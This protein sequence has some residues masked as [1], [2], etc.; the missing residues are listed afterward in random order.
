M[1]D[2][3]PI[4]ILPEGK[5]REQGKGAQRTNIAAARQVADTIRTTLGPLGQDKMLVSGMGDI[6]ITNDGATI[7][8][9]M[10]LE[11]P[12]AKMIAE[13]AKMQEK[14]TGDGTTTAVVIAGELLKNAESLMELNI[15]P[16][17]I[18]KG[19]TMAAEKAVEILEKS[20]ETISMNDKQSLT[21]IAMTAL[22]G[23][24]AEMGQEAFAKLAVNAV[25]TVADNGVDKN[26]IKIVK[27]A[28]SSI[29]ASELIQGLILD[30]ERMHPDMPRVVKQAKIL[31]TDAAIEIRN[32]E[33]KGKLKIRQPGQ[34]QQFLDQ[35]AA[36]I[37][38]IV[39][40]IADSGATALFSQKGVDD[41]AQ[42]MLAKKGIYA[43]RRVMRSD[44]EALAKA[45][46]GRIITNF[47]EIEKDDIGY[48]GSVEGIKIGDEDMTLVKDCKQ[49][50]AVSILLR[51]A[52]E[53]VLSEL[54]RALDDAISVLATVL[55]EGKIV[56][57]AGAPEI[58]T[59][60]QLRKFAAS[61]KGREQL[62]V[63]AFADALEVIPT[64]LAENAGLD[65]ITV[66][67]EVKA[68]H[69]KGKKWEG[70]NVFAGK[71]M[72]AWKDGVLEP[73][74]VK[75]QAISAAAETAVMILRIDDII[76]S[77]RESGQ[78][79]PPSGHGMGMGG[80][81]MPPMM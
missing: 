52:T 15:H 44:L 19:Y 6:V 81:G 37:R 50:K 11:H 28:G 73:L 59:A 25:L 17:V 33:T 48:A 9:E 64:A 72:D 56:A 61:L 38:N 68:A 67:T 1:T 51:G 30:K 8:K 55:A 2:I 74:K 35:E 66:L 4:F 14:E 21:K 46:G 80:M 54:E 77:T 16:T 20:A 31:L 69:D 13:I 71:A 62:A 7:L 5:S 18:A 36:M 58:E 34:I 43:V 53:H 47:N 27:K 60:R 49:A 75:T 57:G 22:R 78:G 32:T 41:S 23:K 79:M 45:T 29:E 65:A 42:Q 39:Q 12:T 76:A 70:V 3:Q 24:S 63:M 40:K 26:N 10:Q